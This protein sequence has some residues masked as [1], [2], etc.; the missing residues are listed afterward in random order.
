MVAICL[1]NDKMNKLT[2][3]RI[4]GNTNMVIVLQC[5]RKDKAKRNPLIITIVI[6]K[7]HITCTYHRL[8]GTDIVHT[9]NFQL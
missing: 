1:R 4:E 2:Q 7:F 5:L 8:Y 6:K 3:G 9:T